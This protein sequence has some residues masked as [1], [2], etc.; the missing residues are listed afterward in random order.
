[1]ASISIGYT[2]Y[3]LPIERAMCIADWLTN[4]EIWEA[5]YHGEGT[6]HPYTYHVYERE[7]HIKFTVTAVS[8]AL[9]QIAKLAGKP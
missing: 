3:V 7:L 9:Y 5:K 6:K 1:M 4:S 2:S 8:P